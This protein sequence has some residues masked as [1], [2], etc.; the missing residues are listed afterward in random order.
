MRRLTHNCKARDPRSAVGGEQGYI[1]DVACSNATAMYCGLQNARSLKVFCAGGGYHDRAGDRVKHNFWLA[2][3]KRQVTE[4]FRS[5]NLHTGMI[6]Y[7]M[8]CPRRV[9]NR[10]TP[11]RHAPSLERV[12][13]ARRAR[14]PQFRPR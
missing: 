9:P 3:E 11:P 14:Q 12:A 8:P 6:E 13:D 5:L 4:I 1:G 10:K 2:G 7:P